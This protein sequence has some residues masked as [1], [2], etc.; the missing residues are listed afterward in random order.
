LRRDL[1]LTLTIALIVVG[2]A[3]RFFGQTTIASLVDGLNLIAIILL[4]AYTG[5]R[6]YRALAFVPLFRL[7][8]A[9]TP[10]FL[11]N[12]IYSYLIAYS[13]MLIPIYAVL[14]ERW[15]SLEE[16]SLTGNGAIYL[17][18]IGSIIGFILGQIERQILG[19]DVAQNMGLQSNLMLL[20][21]VILITGFVEE[22]IFRSMVQTGLEK[23]LGERDGLV[24]AILLFGITYSTYRTLPQVGFG[25]FSGMVIGYLFQRFRSLPFVITIHCIANISLLFIGLNHPFYW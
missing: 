22:F 16:I 20:A 6:I 4:E 21:I 12:A 10:I 5:N 23:R 13:A 19:P 8:S 3:L 15:F 17:I 7:F 1:N 9:S 14:R 18:P 25:L 11:E 2:E 24:I